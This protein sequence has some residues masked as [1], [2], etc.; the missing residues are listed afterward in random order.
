[1]AT[2][3]D[4]YYYGQKGG[5]IIN[6]AVVLKFSEERGFELCFGN[7]AQLPNQQPVWYPDFTQMMDIATTASWSP[8]DLSLDFELPSL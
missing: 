2:Q 5:L 4:G 3:N 8:N 1:M 7:P 6:A